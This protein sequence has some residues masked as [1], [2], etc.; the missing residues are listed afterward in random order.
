MAQIDQRQ[1]DSQLNETTVEPVPPRYWWLKRIGVAVGILLVAL[2]A[3]RVWWGWEASRRLQ[4]EIDRIIAAGEPIF[5]ED[6]DPKEIISDEQNAARLLMEAEA[7]ISLTPQQL[8]VFDKVVY[9]R[10]L[11]VQHLPEVRQI[12]DDNAE[13]FRLVRRAR[14]LT[15][16]DWGLRF[17]SPVS[18]IMPSLSG[19]RQLAKL[20]SLAGNYHYVLG[21]DSETLETIFDALAVG[22]C[23]R[24]Q[25]LLISQMVAWA[26][27][28]I[29]ISRLED[30][31]LVPH[32]NQTYSQPASAVHVRAVIGILSD[33]R[34][35]RIAMRQATWGERMQDVD[36]IRGFDAGSISISSV[37]SG[38]PGAPGSP[39][40]DWV[41]SYILSPAV[42]LSKVRSLYDNRQSLETCQG[43]TLMRMTVAQDDVRSAS[44]FHF[45]LDPLGSYDWRDRMHALFFRQL[46][47]RKLAAAG[48]AARL[49][50][51]EHGHLP[52]TLDELVPGYL[53]TAPK[54]PL[55]SEGRSIGYLPEGQPAI[56]YSVGEDGVDN[57]GQFAVHSR[58]VDRRSL[59][60]PFFLNGGR[61]RPKQETQGVPAPS[62]QSG[63]D[64][65]DTDKGEGDADEDDEGE[66]EP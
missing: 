48:L 7:V 1:P 18:N 34:E 40:P 19:Q 49:Y 8:E 29:A 51:V 15:K 30:M 53:P 6:F 28:E 46:A 39:V 47:L 11:V 33:D 10:D 37:T 64:S 9:E 59:D 31:V 26:T 13:V 21:N 2:F 61:P 45:I 32:S 3:L 57:G 52:R 23:A 38:W 25:P 55:A 14:E 12:V 65:Q 50:Q 22:R 24:Q 63:K 62:A 4:A 58:G 20:L 42:K 5:P 44:M 56:V 66:K 17:R 36:F 16:V 54:D 35:T 60:I 43:D 27:D 41:W